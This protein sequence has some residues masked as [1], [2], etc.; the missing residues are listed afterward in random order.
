MATN[1][2]IW[3]KI[4]PD[5][6]GKTMKCNVLELPNELLKYNYPC[7]D[8]TFH[9]NPSDIWSIDDISNSVCYTVSTEDRGS[10]YSQEA[11][12]NSTQKLGIAHEIADANQQFAFVKSAKSGK[13]YLYSVG[14]KKFVTINGGYT[15]LSETP[16]MGIVFLDG[17][18]SAAYPWV[19]AF[20]TADGE[21]QISVSN[22][23]DPGVITS[24]NDLSDSGNRVRFE[25]AAAFDA[26][27][28][29]EL[30]GYTLTVSDA[31]YGW[32]T[33]VL[34]FNAAIPTDSGFE[35]YT[36]ASV[37]G[38]GI[39]LEPATG[40]LGANTPVIINAPAGEYRFEYTSEAA[41]VTPATDILK[42]TLVNK[43]ITEKV[44]ILSAVDGVVGFYVAKQTDGVFIAK[45][46]KAY[47]VLP[48]EASN[49]S[50]YGFR[51]EETTA[52]EAVEE[53]GAENLIYD[54]SGRRVLV[55]EKGV[56]IVNGKK[57]VIK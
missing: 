41:T 6:F 31:T 33:L 32:A 42:G 43:A 3:L 39:E 28:A 10:W 57:Q 15:A 45:A 8:V 1:A 38:S 49:V 14:E 21:K 44:Y 56:Y 40:V 54:L 36:I 25:K 4:N 46:N 48:A 18:G 50:F 27:E 9:P 53:Q 16:D 5:D 19:V 47:M 17:T 52:V 26:T 30:L 24:W 20:D 11:H 37:D 7:V 29:L 22:G 2:I 23:Y 13:Y 12:L 35:A 34:G 51:D 55:P